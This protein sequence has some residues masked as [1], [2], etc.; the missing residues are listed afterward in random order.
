MEAQ[1][2]NPYEQQLLSVYESCLEIGKSG[3]N[4]KG[5]KLLCDKL[6]LEERSVELIASLLE[7]SSDNH[8]ISFNQFRNGLLSLL[9]NAQEIPD[10]SNNIQIIDESSS[11]M[12][13]NKYDERGSL[14]FECHRLKQ[15]YHNNS[16]DDMNVIIK[17][18]PVM[19]ILDESVISKR[20]LKEIFDKVD[21]NCDG[22]INFNEFLSLFQNERNIDMNSLDDRIWNDRCV[23]GANTNKNQHLIM[24]GPDHTSFIERHVV[25]NLWQMAGVTEPTILLRDLGFTNVNINLIE[26]MAILTDELKSLEH[27]LR[28]ETVTITHVNLLR[29]AL[30]LYQE[31]VRSMNTLNDQLTREKDKLKADVAEANESANIIAQENDETHAKLEKKRQEELKQMELKHAELIK[32]LS[33]QNNS[34]RETYIS[35]VK[36]LNEQLQAVQHEEQLNRDKLADALSENHTLEVDN[37]CLAE[38]ISKLKMSNNQ[39]MRQMQILAAEHDEVERNV[40][41]ENEQV[42][43]LVDRIKKLQTELSLLRDQNDELTSEVESLRAR[44]NHYKA[45]SFDSNTNFSDS[46]ESNGVNDYEPLGKQVPELKD[47]IIDDKV[48]NLSNT[49]ALIIRD[50]KNI[51][52]DRKTPNC[53][54][55]CELKRNLSDIIFTLESQILTKISGKVDA[56]KNEEEECEERTSESL[57]DFVLSK[58]E[59]SR[60]T[61]TLSNNTDDIT[62]NLDINSKCKTLSLRD[63]PPRRGENGQLEQLKSDD[64]KS[65]SLNIKNSID[66]I[67]DIETK[68]I[69]DDRDKLKTLLEEQE[70]KYTNE[71][72]QLQEQCAKL[73]SDL[74]SL[75]TEY[76]QCEDYWASKLEE[77]RQLIE[78]EQKISDEKLGELIAKIAEYEE[79]FSMSDKSRNDGRLSPIEEKFNLEQ[80][81]IDLEDEYEQLKRE[82]QETINEKEN[83]LT[84]LQDKLNDSEVEKVDSGIQVSELED[85]KQIKKSMPLHY[86]LPHELSNVINPSGQA[87]A[88]NINHGMNQKQFGSG[89]LN[90]IVEHSISDNDV[91][92]MPPIMNSKIGN[93]GCSHSCQQ[94]D[95]YCNMDEMTKMHRVELQRISQKRTHNNVSVEYKSLMEQKECLIKEI[96]ELENFYSNRLCSDIDGQVTK[97]DMNFIKNLMAKLQTQDQKR[98]NLQISLKHQK[99]HTEKILEHTWKQHCNEVANL[100]FLLKDTQNSLQHQITMNSMFMEKLSKSDLL[101]KDLY[102]EN[103][104]LKANVERLG[105][106]CHML[107]HLSSGSTSV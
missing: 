25:V 10:H 60:F 107:A 23:D 12:E 80:Q 48:T 78:Q 82:M 53:S 103:A 90:K 6:Q 102:V 58:N 79:Q 36:L 31:E 71:K 54:T 5:L 96:M 32:E 93:S 99:Q 40:E 20:M 69:E 77:E 17:N 100:Q 8:T 2:Y 86:V 65:I 7:Q 21:V 37:Q 85:N 1:G 4:E 9:G 35:K 14:M 24:L 41:K 92:F 98:K 95:T 94:L 13:T 26:L 64:D 29:G 49:V 104:Y 81:Y 22:Q 56:I 46:E 76:Y 38:Q 47:A 106:R 63:Y 19:N 51:T 68:T 27:E 52:L 30:V 91:L 50:L 101:L 42:I 74:E 34:E 62:D 72:K 39:L 55:D 105:E 11:I 28:D 43:S 18:S 83:Q 57:R 70:I 15:L 87:I 75:R 33:M 59:K 16:N 67:N 84:I 3:L 73:E 44:S 88:T 97:I 61:T 45:K 89:K 66:A